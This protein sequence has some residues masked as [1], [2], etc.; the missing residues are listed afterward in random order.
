M[1]YT[2]RFRLPAIGE[3]R[4]KPRPWEEVTGSIVGSFWHPLFEGTVLAGRRPAHARY[5]ADAAGGASGCGDHL[6]GR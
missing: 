5:S 6:A 4:D 1:R 3:I 2:F